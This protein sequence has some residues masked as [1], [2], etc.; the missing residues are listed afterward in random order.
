MIGDPRITNIFGRFGFL[1][2]YPE[3]VDII[4]LT[5]L[6]L[7]WWVEWATIGQQNLYFIMVGW[8]G[9]YRS[10][11]FQCRIYITDAG[12]GIGLKGGIQKF[13]KKGY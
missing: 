13:D 6:I 10:L 9:N 3:N 12:V 11:Q 4:M 5:I 7:S 8:M 1:N 2:I